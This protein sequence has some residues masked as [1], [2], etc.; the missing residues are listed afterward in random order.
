MAPQP[1]PEAV[2][3]RSICLRASDFTHRA[4]VILSDAHRDRNHSGDLI[5][6]TGEGDGAVRHIVHRLVN[7]H[8]FNFIRL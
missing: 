6:Q 1:V 5:L 7:K 8:I 2:M 3:A 4:Q